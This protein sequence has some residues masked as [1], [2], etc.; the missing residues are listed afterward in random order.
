MYYK[1]NRMY[2]IHS[3]HGP[4]VRQYDTL[5][6]ALDELFRLRHSNGGLYRI[7]DNHGREYA[8]I[9]TFATYWPLA[10]EANRKMLKK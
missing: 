9:D 6:E 10:Y 7:L 3:M 4:T 5:S 2:I 1:E 8:R